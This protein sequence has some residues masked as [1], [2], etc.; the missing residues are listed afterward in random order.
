MKQKHVVVLQLFGSNQDQILYLL[1][2]G[3]HV[4]RSLSDVT[5]VS[6]MSLQPIS[7]RVL[8]RWQWLISLVKVSHYHKTKDTNRTAAGGRFGNMIQTEQQT[9]PEHY[10]SHNA[11]AN[12]QFVTSSSYCSFK[13][14]F[15]FSFVLLSVF[16][17]LSL[18][19]FICI[20]K[21]HPETNPALR[22]RL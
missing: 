5:S 18:C 13:M 2:F 17:L 11:S 15:R 22:L 21:T 10:I 9:W 4:A 20:L 7:S 8:V 14:F 12:L 3:Q 6:V 19:S 1:C 16:V